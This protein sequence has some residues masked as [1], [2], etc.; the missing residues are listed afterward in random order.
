MA[1]LTGVE[2]T[3]QKT[4]IEGRWNRV[5]LTEA[6]IAITHTYV[7]TYTCIHSIVLYH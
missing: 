7:Y 1:E 5:F 4:D 6:V 2:I 3:A